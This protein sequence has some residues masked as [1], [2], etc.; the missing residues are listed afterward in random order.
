MNARPLCTFVPQ[1]M[2]DRIAKNARG[3]GVDPD[4]ARRSAIASSAQRQ[5]RRITVSG[6]LA[7]MACMSSSDSPK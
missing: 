3:I 7:S 5:Q 2:L 4:S 6:T 1:R